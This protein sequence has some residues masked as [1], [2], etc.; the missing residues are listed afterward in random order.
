[1]K[2][3]KRIECYREGEWRPLIG[4]NRMS[5]E[6]AKLFVREGGYLRKS[7]PHVEF[8]VVDDCQYNEA[9]A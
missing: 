6:C 3:L 4:L 1:M 9:V 8:R 5:E 2:D 7:W